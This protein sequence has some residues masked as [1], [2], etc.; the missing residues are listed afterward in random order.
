MDE[1]EHLIDEARQIGILICPLSQD[2]DDGAPIERM[3]DDLYRAATMI[4]RLCEC[5]QSLRRR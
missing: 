1:I 2:L 4:G 5:I 3:P